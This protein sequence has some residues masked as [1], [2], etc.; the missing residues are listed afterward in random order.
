MTR[1]NTLYPKLE[2]H[3]LVLDYPDVRG[4]HK[5]VF[6]MTHSHKEV[7]GGEDAVS[8]YNQYEVGIIFTSRLPIMMFN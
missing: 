5:N 6:F 3:S 4:M 2:D 1:R 8:K 7:G